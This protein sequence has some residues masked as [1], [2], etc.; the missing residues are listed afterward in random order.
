MYGISICV[1]FLLMAFALAV[2]IYYFWVVRPQEL[3]K[4][5]LPAV[6]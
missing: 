3:K 2:D 6:E 4:R 5:K 1:L